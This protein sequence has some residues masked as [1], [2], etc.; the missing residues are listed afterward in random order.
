[1]VGIALGR[2]LLAAAFAAPI[3]R[4]WTAAVRTM[5][6]LRIELPDLY[7]GTS[8]LIARCG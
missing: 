8:A 4:L 3:L 7:V 1:M 6:P 2:S 5:A